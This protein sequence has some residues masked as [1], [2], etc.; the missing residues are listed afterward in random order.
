MQTIFSI[1]SFRKVCVFLPVLTLFV[2]FRSRHL[3]SAGRQ[4][5]LLVALLLRGL[6]LAAA[7][8]GVECLPLQSTDA[9]NKY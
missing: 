7:P 2:D 6:S 1:G 9:K 5:S 4:V 8:A 3:L